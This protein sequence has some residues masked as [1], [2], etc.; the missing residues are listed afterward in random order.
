LDHQR[1][2]DQ[3]LSDKDTFYFRYSQGNYSTR[4][5][6]YSQ[7]TLDWNKV[8]SGTQGYKAPNKNGAISWVHTFSPT[9][10]QRTSGERLLRTMVCGTGD[11]THNYDAELGLPNSVRCGRLARPL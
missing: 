2:G 6:F 10:F 5:Q 11:L 1:A 3:R 4:S 7:P 9:L 8:P